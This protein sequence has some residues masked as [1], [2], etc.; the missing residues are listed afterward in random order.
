MGAKWAQQQGPGRGS[1]GWPE[2]IYDMNFQAFL[3]IARA[4]AIYRPLQCLDGI[5]LVQR[6]RDRPGVCQYRGLFHR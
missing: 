4:E 6:V 1:A 2:F 5:F 3:R